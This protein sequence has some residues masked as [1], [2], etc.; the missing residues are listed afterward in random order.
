M[1]DRTVEA[2]ARACHEANRAICETYADQSQTPWSEAE[3]WQ[4]DSAVKGV[5]F[6]LTTRPT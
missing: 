1:T 5:R 6:A 2:I 4:G 3:G